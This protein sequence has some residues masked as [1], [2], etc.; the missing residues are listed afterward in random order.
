MPSDERLRN[1]IAEFRKTRGWSQAE[2]ATRTGI[3]RAAVSA[4]EIHR[5]VPSVATALALA[6]VFQCSVEELF[7]SSSAKTTEPVW[8]WPPVHEPSRFWQVRIGQR[9]VRYPCESIPLGV[10]PHDGIWDRNTVAS[11]SETAPQDTLVLACCDPA[12]SL[13]ARKYNRSSP[14]RLLVLSRSSG[15]ALDLLKKGLVHVAGL[16]LSNGNDRDR[17]LKAAREALGSSAIILRVA[18]WEEGLAL[19][20]E[21]TSKTVHA[22]V[23]SRLSWVGREAGSGAR[24]CLDE[25]IGERRRPKRVAYDHRSV[26]ESIR[27]GWT[28]VGVCHR[29]PCEEAGLRFLPVRSEAYDLCFRAEDASDPRIEALVRVVQSASYRR[30]LAELPGYSC[31]ETG[32]VSAP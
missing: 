5:L 4:I 22:V 17:N 26:A 23:K 20:P 29:L 3:S 13:L 27:S 9:V 19:S 10:I 1:R 21:V 7:G 31:R 24:S 30:I 16:H 28:D 2:L 18:E 25:L 6:G 32:A 14:F 15:K 12:V 11:A 8:A